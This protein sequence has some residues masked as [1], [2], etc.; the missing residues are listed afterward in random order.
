MR[1][2]PYISSLAALRQRK[3][4]GYKPMTLEQSQSYP[5]AGNAPILSLQAINRHELSWTS[6]SDCLFLQ[7]SRQLCLSHL[8]NEFVFYDMSTLY[9]ASFC[10]AM[11]SLQ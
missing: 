11:N 8:S 10:T 2:Y 1:R 3:K 7:I 9:T 4:A 6:Y 5:I